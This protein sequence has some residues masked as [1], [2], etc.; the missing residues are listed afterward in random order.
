[1][2][3]PTKEQTREA[4]LKAMNRGDIDTAAKIGI[5]SALTPESADVFS[6][7]LLGL[8]ASLMLAREE[9]FTGDDL[10][11][12]QK[13]IDHACEKAKV[14]ISLENRKLLEGIN[15]KWVAKERVLYEGASC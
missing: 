6:V 5:Y 7:A 12:T 8:A 4:F 13:G 10:D 14:E 2:E 3:E 1:M 11:Y 9:G 15:V